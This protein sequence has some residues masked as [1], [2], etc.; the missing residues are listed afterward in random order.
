MSHL[1][2]AQSASIATFAAILLLGGVVPASAQ[3]V[4]GPTNHHP[5]PYATINDYFVLPDGREWGSTS[6]VDI[7]PDG[8]SIWV[9][10]RCGA[11]SCAASDVDPWYERNDGR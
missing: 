11:N 2:F 10:E 6:A 9:A 7:A 1:C 3:L 8:T 5:N 4:N